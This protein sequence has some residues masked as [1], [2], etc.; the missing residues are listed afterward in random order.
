MRRRPVYLQGQGLACAL[1]Q[2]LPQ[3][4]SAWAAGAT[5]PLQRRVLGAAVGAGELAVAFRPLPDAQAPCD[6]DLDGDL[7]GARWLQR[8]LHHLER[9]VAE[10]GAD[11]RGALLLAT[12]SQDI[13]RIERGG[14]WYADGFGFP[15]AIARQL[16][17]QGPVLT[18]TTA[19]TSAV[20][21]LRQAQTLVA[22]GEVPSA[23]VLGVELSSRFT[24]SGFAALQL[25]AE[26]PEGAQVP[27]AGLVLGEAVA[28]LSI[29]PAESR[30]RLCGAGHCV[31]GS[32]PAGPTGVAIGRAVQAALNQ[33]GWSGSEVGHIKA[34]ATGQPGSD[35]LEDEWLNRLLPH[36]P[37]RTR[38]K[39]LLGHT[40]GASA[41]AE[42]ALMTAGP[43]LPGL[44]AD[45][46]GLLALN[47]GFGGCHGALLLEDAAATARGQA[48][49]H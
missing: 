36:R 27:T 35:V 34:H 44:D 24:L 26:W 16:G 22:Q 5:P 1:G 20:N 32:D 21:A 3:C 25:L 19:C 15:E 49:A 40:Q 11:R 31:S 18:V 8:G 9:V 6:D 29:G 14:G 30:W 7:D 48:D 38:L 23:L 4:L 39:A 2:T 33:A 17:W 37:E 42:L 46:P 10:A 28:A 45:R 12:S 47:L 13:G 41:A 43:P